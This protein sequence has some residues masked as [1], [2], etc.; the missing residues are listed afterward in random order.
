MKIKTRSKMIEEMVNSLPKSK[1]GY[2]KRNLEKFDKK[3][4]LGFYKEWEKR[5][6]L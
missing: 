1:Q 2:E 3:R 6:R 5:L 4:I